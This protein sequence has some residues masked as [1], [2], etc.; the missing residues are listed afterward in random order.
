M[1]EKCIIMGD[2]CIK[3][4]PPA[5]G[6][7]QGAFAPDPIYGNEDRITKASLA[8]FE[9]ISG[10][11]LDIVLKFLDFGSSGLY[12][13][14]KD[15]KTVT[16]K[17]GVI[18]I[19]L[20]PWNW[21]NKKSKEFSL[22]NI[23]A[24][25]ADKY[26]KRFA[27]GAKKFGKPIFV[28]FAHEMNAH[29]YPWGNQESGTYIK[30]YRRV[31]EVISKIAPNITWVWTPDVKNPIQDYYPGD[32]YVDWV[33]ID[34]YNWDNKKTAAQIF[35]ERLAE[36][37]A[38]KKPTMIG[39]F[40]C[41]K[42]SGSCVTDF[43]NFVTQNQ[44]LKAYVFYNKDQIQDGSWKYFALKTPGEKAAYAQ[45]VKKNEK[46][47][48]SVILSQTGTCATPSPAASTPPTAAVTTTPPDVKFTF[49][50]ANKVF[51]YSD[52]QIK[53]IDEV[54][55]DLR[56]DI[57]DEKKLDDAKLTNKLASLRKKL[58][59][60]L[61]SKWLL[62][63]E[64][65]SADT[66]NLDEGLKYGKTN[67]W[68][69]LLAMLF[70]TNP[71]LGKKYLPRLSNDA[72]YKISKHIS[73]AEQLELL[74]KVYQDF[75]GPKGDRRLQAE[76]LT[77]RALLAWQLGDVTEFDKLSKQ[78]ENLI[79]YYQETNNKT[80]VTNH[81]KARMA[82]APKDDIDKEYKYGLGKV[83]SLEAQL[84]MAKAGD[85]L[86]E[87]EKAYKLAAE[88]SRDL[89]GL[90]N[91][92]T[93]LLA[94][95]ILVRQGFIL[96]NQGNDPGPKF[97]KAA[98]FAASILDFEKKYLAHPGFK[99]QAPRWLK[100]MSG[101][102]LIWQAKAEMFE[103]G[104]IVNGSPKESLKLQ[105]DALHKAFQTLQKVLARKEYLD[106]STLADIE[107]TLGE[108]LALQGFI[109]AEQGDKNYS[110][111]LKKAKDHLAEAVTKGVNGTRAAA[112]LWLAKV[113]TVEAGKAANPKDKKDLLTQAE[114]HVKEALAATTKGYVLKNSELSSAFQTYGD[115]HAARKDFA[116]AKDQYQKALAKS[117]NN[118]YARVSLADIHNWTR[119]YGK[120]IQEY[121]Q[122]IANAPQH[123]S[124]YNRAQL[125]KLE[126]T[127][128]RDQAY[129][130]ILKEAE[131][132][133][134]IFEGEAKASPLIPRAIDFIFESYTAEASLQKQVIN[135]ANHILGT[136]F[137]STVA[138]DAIVQLLGKNIQAKNIDT[139]SLKSAFKARLYLSL[140]QALTWDEDGRFKDADKAI[141]Q[142]RA[143]HDK[144][145]KA[146]KAL[147]ITYQMTEAIIKLRKDKK[148]TPEVYAAVKRVFTEMPDDVNLIQEGLK[149]L[150]EEFLVE[151][152]NDKIIL[153]AD[154][155]L[156]MGLY[157]PDKSEKELLQAFEKEHV[158][159][160]A[161]TSQQIKIA[162]NH[163][164]AKAIE[165]V[166]ADHDQMKAFGQI[167]FDLLFRLIA[168]L[169]W[170]KKFQKALE[171][172]RDI[173]NMPEFKDCTCL[174]KASFYITLGEIFRYGQGT[175][176]HAEARK[177]Y[178]EAIKLLETV[179]EDKRNQPYFILMAKAHFGLTKILQQNG[180]T[181]KAKFQ[182]KKTK[183]YL[184]AAGESDEL[185]EI[186]NDTYRTSA[187]L[188]DP[189]AGI[190]LDS[191][192]DRDG[193]IESQL[194]LLAQFPL[195]NG[196]FVPQLS[197]QLDMADGLNIHSG[198]AGFKFRPLDIGD[199]GHHSLTLETRFKLFQQN[200]YADPSAVLKYF[201][202]YDNST[203]LF[204][205]NKYF[206]AGTSMGFDFQ[207]AGRNSY[208]ATFM[209]NLTHYM[210]LGVEYNHYYFAFSEG[211]KVRD[212]FNAAFKLNLDLAQLGILP[213]YDR[214]KVS[215]YVGYPYFQY[216][217]T[218]GKLLYDPTSMKLGIG[219]DIHLGW[220]LKLMLGC[221]YTRQ[222][223]YNYGL[224][225]VGVGW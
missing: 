133:K 206:M 17:G 28:S 137:A 14:A 165:K 82:G 123:S 173:P 21:N 199:P 194:Q 116:Q 135:I 196:I 219:A 93:H 25:K 223:D 167:K 162:L 115:I 94:V 24:G 36:A 178:H 29:W 140:A 131:V 207:D 200:D 112:H 33:A 132:F 38:Y 182:L 74:E 2:T 106:A 153:L 4:Q 122:V 161:A 46:L 59:G 180:K 31:H 220:G 83:N 121:E 64:K 193:R 214:A 44:D 158:P 99:G 109:L 72:A 188:L 205:S 18:F 6:L 201:R 110:P 62:L 181:K 164:S 215:A 53:K 144:V 185:K 127:V 113:L 52:A 120:A 57:A 189:Y 34:G 78:A 211:S 150:L 63:R 32:A 169:A 128:R 48:K 190:K 45:A 218:D 141:K 95:E 198:H 146:D 168:A 91:V 156:K 217:E 147:D 51:G 8:A 88:A 179:P 10:A 225:S 70:V 67:F 22:E 160:L 130:G 176:Q 210:Q 102:A 208:Y 118:D 138:P 100:Q 191:F 12:F 177:N 192:M 5:S 40:A 75:I 209:A 98:K 155:L 87:L 213:Q 202:Q 68:K 16:K 56:A 27:E 139:S 175:I 41:A 145:I 71:E 7:Y 152:R 15:A 114:K 9:K 90:E 13:P 85:D 61:F 125:G 108:N 26:L 157:A 37:K 66:S 204:Y 58:S 222:S 149:V 50:S 212:D 89:G 142:G 159:K 86:T 186:K 54:I 195:F 105:K 39:E 107:L 11:D 60:L 96:A 19:K 97:N 35:G 119:E 136:S 30:A 76:N 221:S 216:D 163:T 81:I 224:C 151:E 65:G 42:N 47:F 143:A 84:T 92:E 69:G 148:Y 73:K 184:A 111:Q 172:G 124:A 117:K 77:K 187:F 23:A 55:N 134:A 183:E 101:Q 197:Y 103:A 126:A 79:N 203:S 43:M 154:H 174:E 1:Q 170:S 20:E 166:F 104:A 129:A 80:A 3:I 49:V 171:L